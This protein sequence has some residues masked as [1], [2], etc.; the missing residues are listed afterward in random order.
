MGMLG[1]TVKIFY[2]CNCA[3]KN[4][5]KVLFR[6]RVLLYLLILL[7]VLPHKLSYW[8]QVFNMLFHQNPWSVLLFIGQ[9]RADTYHKVSWCETW[10][11]K[12]EEWSGDPC[13]ICNH[14][15]SVYKQRDST[16]PNEIILQAKVS[17]AWKYLDYL[18]KI[19]LS[20]TCILL[21]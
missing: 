6:W 21:F 18:T 3:L 11:F 14:S 15:C 19:Q 2:K 10:H 9:C 17:E 20:L 13:L 7:T 8:P 1:T 5:W 16:R 4:S 12:R